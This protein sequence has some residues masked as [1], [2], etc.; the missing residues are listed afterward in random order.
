MTKR[1]NSNAKPVN[2]N[3]FKAGVVA[4]PVN[5]NDFKAGVVAKQVNFKPV[6]LEAVNKAVSSKDDTAVSSSTAVKDD[7]R[8]DE[9]IQSVP[10]RVQGFQV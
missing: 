10:D 3:D 5:F 2:I 6:G 4:K 1:L 8:G 9:M 7:R